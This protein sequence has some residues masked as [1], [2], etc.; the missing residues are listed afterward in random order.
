M[1]IIEVY[2]IIGK[3]VK[4]YPVQT[5]DYE[6][7]NAFFVLNDPAFI[8]TGSQGKTKI[9]AETAENRK[10]FFN[11][12]WEDTGFD[13]D[14]TSFDFPMLCLFQN[15]FRSLDLHR[16]T[17]ELDLYAI[18]KYEVDESNVVWELTDVAQERILVNVLMQFEDFVKFNGV[19][20]HNSTLNNTELNQVTESVKQAFKNRNSLSF[21]RE[22][23]GTQKLSACTC[24]VDLQ[25]TNCDSVGFVWE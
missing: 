5:N 22:Y 11:R 13:V 21:N 8:N 17:Y 15:S 18:G 20:V 7:P 12:K 25:L 2:E 24:K 6:R 1:T 14:D 4:Q 10:V 9:Y 3:I 19:W 16:F 23:I